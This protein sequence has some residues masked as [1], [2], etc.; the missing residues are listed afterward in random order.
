MHLVDESLLRDARQHGHDAKEVV[1][2]V[3]DA[4]RGAAAKGARV[5]ICTCSTVGNAAESTP[6]HGQFTAMRID[7]AMADAAARCG[8]RVLVVAA[9]Q[10]TLAPT[11]ALVHDSAR[12][13]QL[14]IEV[15]EHAIPGAWEQFERGDMAAYYGEISRAVRKLLPGPNVVVLAQ[16]SMAPAAAQLQSCTVPVL[17]SPELGLRAALDLHMGA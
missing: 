17:S 13:L 6:T 12:R 2:R 1:A 9:L 10:S 8:P 11:A 4:V 7:R 3:H 15:S 14:P 5:V 16:A